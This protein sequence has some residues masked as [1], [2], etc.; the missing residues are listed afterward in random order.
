MKMNSALK[1]KTAE[2]I[3]SALALVLL[4][5]LSLW[6]AAA[7]LAGSIVGLAAFGFL[8]RERLRGGSWRVAFSVAVAAGL[9]VAVAIAVS[10]VQPR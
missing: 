7:M 4:L 1:A 2:S 10:L 3:F 5:I 9:A 6:G 8:F